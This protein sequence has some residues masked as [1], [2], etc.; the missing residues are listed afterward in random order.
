MLQD[1]QA[2]IFDAVAKD[3]DSLDKKIKSIVDG[4]VKKY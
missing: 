2:E 3:L 4:I 1:M